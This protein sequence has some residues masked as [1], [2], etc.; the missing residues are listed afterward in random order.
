MKIVTDSASLFSPEEGKALGIEV[1]PACAVINGEVYR[2]FEDISSEEFL[3]RIQEGAVPTSSQPSVGDFMEVFEGEEEIL[4]LSIGDGLSGGYQ[5]AMGVKNLLEK[6]DHI[7]VVDT[8]TLAGPEHYMVEKALRLKKE[9]WNIEKIKKELQ[10]CIEHSVSFVIP[11]DFD[12]LK[13]S[14]RLIPLAAKIGGMIKIVPVMTQTEDM[15]RIKPFV[16]TRSKKKAVEAI[17]QHLKSMGVNKDY[18]ISVAHAGVLEQARAVLAQLKEH[19][20][21]TTTELFALSPALITHGGPG[22]ITIQAVRK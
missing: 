14:G 22:S 3:K 1:V 12:F 2:D 18:V 20:G 6:N 7:H 5:N 15:R 19:F 11:A 8:K 4:F 13:R 10:Q 16:I 21:D 9:G 17:I